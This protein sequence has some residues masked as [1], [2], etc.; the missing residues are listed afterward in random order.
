MKIN[1]LIVLAVALLMSTIFA[2]VLAAQIGDRTELSTDSETISFSSAVLWAGN[3][4]INR[5]LLTA[6][7]SVTGEDFSIVAYS[8]VVCY[9]MNVTNQSTGAVITSGNYTITNCNIKTKLG[10][11]YDTE[12]LN[13]S[14]VYNY[15]TAI[16][17]SIN[18]YPTHY[19]EAASGWR[20]D[21]IGCSATEIITSVNMTNSTGEQFIEGTD[22]EVNFATGSFNLTNTDK[23]NKSIDYVAQFG[24][25][26][27]G[28]NYVSGWGNS[29]LKMIPG[30]FVLMILGSCFVLVK[31]FEE[32][33]KGS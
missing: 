22:W 27:C 10:G 17:S 7:D 33:K 31:I 20:T 3:A 15:R 6:V 8:G 26:Y 28:D 11:E 25:V 4:S 2:G 19:V 12:S 1:I 13:V 24:V 29:T 21:A 14:Y 9:L 23:V 30:F 18:F 32:A 16:N 5:E